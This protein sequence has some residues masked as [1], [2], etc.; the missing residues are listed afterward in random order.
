MELVRRYFNFRPSLPLRQQAASGS[1]LLTKSHG[2]HNLNLCK[3]CNDLDLESLAYHSPHVHLKN[4]FELIKTSEQCRFCAFISHTIQNGRS[5]NL[6]NVLIAYD[7][8]P[9]SN[10]PLCLSLR[11]G[12]L[13]VILGERGCV[14]ALDI[15]SESGRFIQGPFP[16]SS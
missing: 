8:V 5:R 10:I 4:C 2:L 9:D 6:R 11:S 13:E 12:C 3:T 1:Y 7:I 16:T 14:A 15:Y